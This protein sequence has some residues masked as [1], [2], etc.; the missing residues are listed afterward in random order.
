MDNPALLLVGTKCD[1]ARQRQ[2]EFE[3]AQVRITTCIY[4]V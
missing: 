2:V 3:E 1:D 4:Y